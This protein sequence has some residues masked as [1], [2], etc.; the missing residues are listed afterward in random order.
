MV[1]FLSAKVRAEVFT[2]TSNADSGPG[3]LREALTL[4]AANGS[5]EKDFIYFNLPDVSEAGRTIALLTQLPNITSNISIDASTQPGVKFGVTDA[6]VKLTL[7]FTIPDNLKVFYSNGADF[8]EIYGVWF[9]CD[10]N[11]VGGSAIELKSFNTVTIGAPGKGN[12]FESGN[13]IVN[14]GKLCSFKSNICWVDKSGEIARGGGLYLFSCANVI[15]GGSAD[16]KNVIA[17]LT[18]IF[19]DGPAVNS[20]DLSYNLMGTNYTGTKAP[21]GFNLIN[22]TRVRV[23]GTYVV[24]GTRQYTPL[25]AVIKNNIIAD[26]YGADLLYMNSVK[27]SIVIQGNAFN[28]DFAGL[29]N[30]N[31]FSQSI[32]FNAISLS[33]DADVL[34]GGPTPSDKN[35]IAYCLDGIVLSPPDNKN[36]AKKFVI[37]RN[38]IF[39]VGFISAVN[40]TEVDKLPFVKIA[41][42]SNTGISGTSTPNADVELFYAGCGCS[43]IPTPKD[44]F[45]TVKADANGN[46]V[47]SGAVSGYVMA[48]ATIN[49]LTGLFTGLNINEDK[50]VIVN[51][52]CGKKG[53]VTGINTPYTFGYRWYNDKNQLVSSQ[54]DL[55]DKDAGI[56]TLKVGSGG[57]CDI[58][59]TY[60]IKD[61]SITVDLN[62]LQYTDATCTAA[63]SIKG[64]VIHTQS[65]QFYHRWLDATGAVVCDCTDLDAATAGSYTFEVG[66]NDGT[67][68]QKFGPFMVKNKDAP[69]IVESS[70]TTNPSNC[71]SPTGSIKGVYATGGTG[72]LQYSWRNA[73]DHEVGTLPELTSA[74]AG[75]YRLRV[76]D[77]TSCPPVYSTEIEILESNGVSLDR[78][79]QGGLSATCN[80]ANGSITGLQASGATT[81]KWVVTG[82]STTISDKPDLKDVE[83]GLYTLTI[84]NTTC[85]RSY[86][87]EVA[88]FPPTVFTGIT[89]T[90]TKTCDA[91]PTGTITL[92]T[93]NANE[94]P[95]KYRWVNSAGENVGFDKTVQFLPAGNY[96]VYLTDKNFCENQLPGTF[97]VETYPEFKVLSFG[98]VTNTQCGV[99]TGGVSE[100]RVTGG[101]GAYTYQW[102]NADDNDNPIP[103]KKEASITGLLPGHYKL[104]ITDGGCNKA[105]PPYNIVDVS[106]TPPPPSATNIALCSAGPAI[107]TVDDAFATAI[108]RLYDTETSLTPIDEEIGGKFNINITGSR[109][110]YVTLTYGYCEST[111]AEV[112][113]ALGTITNGI[114]NTFTPNGDGINDY[115][116]IKGIENYTNGI[117]S[118]FNRGGQLVFQS[119]GYPKPFDGTYNGKPLP[120]GVYYYIINLK[121]CSLISGNVTIIR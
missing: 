53:S 38:S 95:T 32:A 86:D 37:S 70:Y 100:T 89:Y 79:G 40:S 11:S 64:V 102:L 36:P 20:L 62:N 72:T 81:Y 3:T 48:S 24:S 4:A 65:A 29:A 19:F 60:E 68:K 78:T 114:A 52:T 112:K 43:S 30:F 85:S 25:N 5:A 47:Y 93:E 98:T 50:L 58:T 118:V 91:F 16:A 115:W 54:R 82:T 9:D 77:G 96:T 14:N 57:E 111:R 45:A 61:M 94:Q 42:V 92:N 108:Y 76:N 121:S 46:W 110:Y 1:V 63:G 51:E 49:N 97:T 33:V 10:N 23:E 104:R 28:T 59:K 117:I 15:I 74:F 67:C 8:I 80:Q 12:F 83:A 55:I 107:I 26:V 88:G 41:S 99:G 39:C 103:G 113:V 69:V 116:N 109:S 6:K 73:Q 66:N 120:A 56:Y 27:G 35:L 90:K 34:I 87:F 106:A 119:K 22:Q 21:Y 75:K 84:S 7:K 18:E 71:N 31:E 101:T 44:Y 2:V 17:G 13:V 105:E